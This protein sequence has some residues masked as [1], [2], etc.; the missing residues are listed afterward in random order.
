LFFTN[1]NKKEVVQWFDSYQKPDYPKTG[2]VSTKTYSLSL[3]HTSFP[4]LFSFSLWCSLLLFSLWDAYAPQ[5]LFL[6][7]CGIRRILDI[8]SFHLLAA[9][10]CSSPF[11]AH[12]LLPLCADVKK[13]ALNVPFS[14][15]PQLRKLGLP[16]Q[17]KNGVVELLQDTIICKKGDT[18]SPE[19]C[20]LLV[21]AARSSS[22]RFSLFASCFLCE[23][24][25]RNEK[26]RAFFSS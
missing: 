13:A 17:L 14:L 16:T 19:Q 9:S 20:K 25:E 7:V 10:S 5:A 12:V 21:S 2:F 18:L 4:S 6:C 8:L 26:K 23:K 22:S 15:E 24:K 3:F 11:Y 1:S